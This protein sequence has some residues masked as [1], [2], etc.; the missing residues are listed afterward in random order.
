MR[1]V[2]CDAS[3]VGLP[4]TRC[5]KNNVTDCQFIISR[6]GTYDR[7]KAKTTDNGDS[8]TERD[9]ETNEP[10]RMSWSSIMDKVFKAKQQQSREE[11][12][13]KAMAYHGENSLLSFMLGHGTSEGNDKVKV[14]LYH[15]IG[16]SS[17]LNEHLTQQ[18][19]ALMES[20]GAFTRCNSKSE[21]ELVL[22]FFQKLFPIY[23]IFNRREFWED[24]ENDKTPWI[25]LHAICFMSSSYASES[26]IKACGFPNRAK[27]NLTFYTRAKSLF[28]L[29]YERNKLVLVQSLLLLSFHVGQP[30]DIW[31]THTWIGMA[32][33]TAETLGIHRSMKYCNIPKRDQSLFKRLWWVLFNRDCAM[34][35]LFGRTPRT[36]VDHC[37]K[38]LHEF[39]D[40][41]E[42]SEDVEILYQLHLTKL[43]FIHRDITVYRWNSD[44]SSSRVF[45]L[46]NRVREWKNQLPAVLLFEGDNDNIFSM[47][48]E[49]IY[50][51][52][53][54]HLHL[55][56]KQN[57]TIALVDIATKRITTIARYLVTSSLAS[58]M[59]HECFPAIFAAEVVLYCQMKQKHDTDVDLERAQIDIC[60]MFLK[61][62]C[63]FWGSASWIMH[64]FDVLLSRMD[65]NSEA[66]KLDSEDSDKLFDV[67][68]NDFISFLGAWQEN[69]PAIN[70]DAP[71]LNFL[72]DR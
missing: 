64:L 17:W 63:D 15:D 38:E 28:D 1:R 8:P 29:G 30:D 20:K 60:Q 23:P 22:L 67:G 24:Y 13:T 72:L 46:C 68:L 36:N 26:L 9:S 61:E 4:C 58:N 39:D 6:R 41:D 59:P 62:I 42:E 21:R 43:T 49:L 2:K 33:S 57:S 56:G 35:S 71:D 16:N 14:Q 5:K 55:Q 45:P 51:H 54:I 3:E 27:A 37:D 18:E 11:I 66:S 53:L 70:F 50:N 19:V 25:L 32:T 40:F 7:K 12:N 69:Q 47:A 65:K 48:L 34:A 44:D 10:D 31:Y 52:H